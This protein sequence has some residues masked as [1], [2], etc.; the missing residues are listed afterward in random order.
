MSARFAQRVARSPRR[1]IPDFAVDAGY[2]PVFQ[3]HPLAHVGSGY[4]RRQVIAGNH[5]RK[6]PRPNAFT[7]EPHVSFSSPSWPRG[8]G[9][10]RQR[11]PL[12]R[13]A[14][15]ER[16]DELSHSSAEIVRHRDRDHPEYP[17]HDDQPVG[18]C[19]RDLYAK[20]PTWALP[21]LTRCK[22]RR[23]PRRSDPRAGDPAMMVGRSRVNEDRTYYAELSRRTRNRLDDRHAHITRSSAPTS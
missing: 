16:E 18:S 7:E 22:K 9:S 2:V 3:W 13:E 1:M 11:S 17:R 23:A 5:V 20:H 6:P 10:H 21:I 8:T 14:V 12:R 19:R 4:A 15:R